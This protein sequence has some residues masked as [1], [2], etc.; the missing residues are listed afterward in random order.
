MRWKQASNER[1]KIDGGNEQKIFA[2]M[3]RSEGEDILS[4]NEAAYQSS[5]ASSLRETREHQPHELA[6][7]AVPTRHCRQVDRANGSSDENGSLG[8]GEVEGTFSPGL[9]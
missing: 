9:W 2:L 6:A 4:K 7:E 1:K 8:E 3:I 5:F